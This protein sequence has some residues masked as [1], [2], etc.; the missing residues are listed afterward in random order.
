MH[1]PQRV[2][3]TAAKQLKVHHHNVPVRR[4]C[5]M[6]RTFLSTLRLRRSKGVT[7]VE[8]PVP[9]K[10]NAVALM[11][12]QNSETQFRHEIFLHKCGLPVDKAPSD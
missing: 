9:T 12:F 7:V 1:Q 2:D 3:S 8:I 6:L 5:A 11:F 4:F 10:F